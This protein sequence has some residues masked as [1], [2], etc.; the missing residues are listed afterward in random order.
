MRLF[1]FTLEND[2][3]R[4]IVNLVSCLLNMSSESGGVWSRNRKNTQ[5][6]K[7]SFY[8]CC[9]SR[10]FKPH[11]NRN[12]KTTINDFGVWFGTFGERS[13][14]GC[15]TSVFSEH[16]F[17]YTSLETLV[18]QLD[19]EEAQPPDPSVGRP[20]TA[21]AHNFSQNLKLSPQTRWSPS[22]QACLLPPLLH[23]CVSSWGV[24]V[25][26]SLSLLLSAGRLI[27]QSFLIYERI[28]SANQTKW[29]PGPWRYTY[30]ESEGDK[31]NDSWAMRSTYRKTEISRIHRHTVY[32]W[33]LKKWDIYFGL[34][35][36]QCFVLSYR[37]HTDPSSLWK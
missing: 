19:C 34:S 8:L 6:W 12:L 10:F 28:T 20:G 18:E 37:L 3:R 25:D 29:K 7:E 17:S 14:F 4:W 35:L 9:L 13:I 21:S 2:R 23:T 36:P 32:I 5:S 1:S 27:N 31:M 26:E 15:K 30:A 22:K 11:M 16:R 33:A 24:Y